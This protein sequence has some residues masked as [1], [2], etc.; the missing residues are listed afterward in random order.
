[1]KTKKIKISHLLQNSAIRFSKKMK[2]INM[3]SVKQRGSNELHIYKYVN[4]NT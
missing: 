3:E 4:F 1:M 2:L